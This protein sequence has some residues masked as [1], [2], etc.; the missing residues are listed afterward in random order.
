MFI[1]LFLYKLYAI[2]FC[3]LLEAFKSING[4]YKLGALIIPTNKHDS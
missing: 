2:V 3:F 1:I 4:E